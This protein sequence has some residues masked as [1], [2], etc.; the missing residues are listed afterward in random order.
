MVDVM[1]YT[2][3]VERL[4]RFLH[5]PHETIGRFAD[6]ESAEGFAEWMHRHHPQW[7]VQVEGGER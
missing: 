4:P 1:S 2:V 3:S 7:R 5:P 6:D